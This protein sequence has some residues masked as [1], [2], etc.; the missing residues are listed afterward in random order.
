MKEGLFVPMPRVFISKS[1]IHLN[2][3]I[4]EL[5]NFLV[6]FVQVSVFSL[7]LMKYT[8]ENSFEK[9]VPPGIELFKS[10]ELTTFLNSPQ[11]QCTLIDESKP[12][13]NDL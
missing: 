3:L 10:D 4:L 12:G 13:A 1:V 8:E 9:Y 2:I 7:N 11:V 5:H 6:S